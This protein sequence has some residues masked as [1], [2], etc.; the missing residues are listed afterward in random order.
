MSSETS[1]PVRDLQDIAPVTYSPVEATKIVKDAYERGFHA[2]RLGKTGLLSM[3]STAKQPKYTISSEYSIKNLA[4]KKELKPHLYE[5][6]AAAFWHLIQD[7][8]DQLICLR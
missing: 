7:E 6:A 4:W 5:I 8:E 1:L 3:H 2:I